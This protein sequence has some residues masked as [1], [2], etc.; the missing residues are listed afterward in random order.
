M[1]KRIFTDPKYPVYIISKGRSEYMITS[2]ALAN[3]RVKHYITVEPQE[4]ELYKAAVIKF[5]LQEYTTI[6][7]LPFSNH[8]DGP[9][10]ARNWCWDHSKDILCAKRHW[11]LDDNIRGF[12]RSHQNMRIEVHSGVFFRIMEDFA[13]RYKNVYIC[14]PQ[15]KFFLFTTSQYPPILVNTRVYSCL[16]IDNSMPFKWRGRYNEDTDICLRVLKSG[17]CVVQFYCLSQDKI[18]TQV[19]KG[20][21]T[22]E[23]YHKEGV[24]NPSD[25]IKGEYNQ[26]G[27]VNK[28]QMLY[29]MH[30]DVTKLVHRF[31]RPHHYVD[32][33]PFKN[34]ELIFV[35]DYV[36]P[37]E[38]NNYGMIL[39]KRDSD[40][41]TGN[42]P[43]KN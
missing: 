2:K 9:G 38:S 24:K 16:L 22:D 39:T 36:E 42:S 26:A 37:T 12:L 5:N 28:S 17:N 33:S 43:L 18:A 7:E 19:L 6:L 27:T 8:G 4:L 30:P 35:D 1:S 23:F 10:R 31:G 25:L 20:G 13:D 3:M 32:Y 11:V 41:Y 34:N 14:G 40:I 15:Y 29:D 21:N